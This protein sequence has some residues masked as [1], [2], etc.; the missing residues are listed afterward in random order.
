MKNIKSYKLFDSTVYKSKSKFEDYNIILD[1]QDILLELEDNNISCRIWINNYRGIQNP[2]HLTTPEDV[3][4]ITKDKKLDKINNIEIEISYDDY[5]YDDEDCK[6]LINDV[7]ERIKAYL[8]TNSKYSINRKNYDDD[9]YIMLEININKAL[10]S[11]IIKRIKDYLKPIEIPKISLEDVKNIIK[12]CLIDLEDEGFNIKTDIQNSN[13]YRSKYGETKFGNYRDIIFV[14]IKNESSS[15]LNNFGYE[16]SFILND[17][18]IIEIKDAVMTLY[19][20]IKSDFGIE[21]QFIYSKDDRVSIDQFN[22]KIMKDGF[23]NIISYKKLDNI[24]DDDKT[25][26]SQFHIKMEI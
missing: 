2:I 5:D 20:I 11:N 3:I 21:C 10:E 17:F 16:S 1:I 9:S 15:L 12:D 23:K 14:T 24:S 4:Q 13:I 7:I 6:I 25:M 18:K 8:N 26:I 19:D 22:V